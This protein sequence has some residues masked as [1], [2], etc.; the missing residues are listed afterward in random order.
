MTTLFPAMRQRRH[1]VM[2]YAVNGNHIET[3]GHLFDDKPVLEAVTAF[4]DDSQI[5]ELSHPYV[6]NFSHWLHDA[7][8]LLLALLQTGR[9]VKKVEV[10]HTAIFSVHVRRWLDLLGV[11]CSLLSSETKIEINYPLAWTS[12]VHPKGL[13]TLRVHIDAAK[14]KHTYSRELIL[15]VLR[16]QFGPSLQSSRNLETMNEL[17][18]LLADLGAET[19]YLDNMPILQQIALFNSARAIIATHGAALGNVVFCKPGCVVFEISSPLFWNSTF[20]EIGAYLGL[21]YSV[22]RGVERHGS[23]NLYRHSLWAPAKELCERLRHKLQI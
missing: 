5:L 18:N 8:P 6:T 21:D 10:H 23:R 14:K 12:L 20:A 19:V 4:E 13:E 7:L 1:K 2:R 3:A 11:K 16:N 9:I 17:A 15:L 22:I